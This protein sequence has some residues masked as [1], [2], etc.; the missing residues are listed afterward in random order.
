MATPHFIE[1]DLTDDWFASID[2]DFVISLILIFGR[3][4]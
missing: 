3:R 4:D 1:A 2:W